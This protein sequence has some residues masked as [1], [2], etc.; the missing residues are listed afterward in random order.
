MK[1]KSLCHSEGPARSPRLRE[2]E[3]GHSIEPEAR[4][5]G[6]EESLLKKVSIVVILLGLFVSP[7]VASAQLDTSAPVD[8]GLLTGLLG[9]SDNTIGCVVLAVIKALLALAFL[10]TILFM[11]ISGFRYVTSAG[12]EE[13]VTAAK[14][15]LIW[16]IVGI[17]VILLAWVILSIVVNAIEK[18]PGGGGDD[19]DYDYTYKQNER[20]FTKIPDYPIIQIERKV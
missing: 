17:V 3:A 14:Q 18:G 20:M 16:A 1:K 8:S 7:I 9:C 6:A 19:D 15:N 2:S 10:A 12:N 11:V 13:A 4:R 5:V